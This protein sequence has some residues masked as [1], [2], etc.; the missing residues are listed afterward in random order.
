M[1]SKSSG[2]LHI[3][4]FCTAYDQLTTK[5][6]LIMELLYSA[7][8]FFNSRHLNKREAF[9]ALRILMTNDL[10]IANLADSVKKL[11]QVALRSVER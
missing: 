6:L 4:S 10:G 5:K 8:S 3:R 1:Y 9:G 7:A 11:E 2:P